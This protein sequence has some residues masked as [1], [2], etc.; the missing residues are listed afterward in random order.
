MSSSLDQV[1][2]ASL[3]TAK[4]EAGEAPPARADLL[5]GSVGEAYFTAERLIR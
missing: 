2:E 3:L 5:Q 1:L 4:D